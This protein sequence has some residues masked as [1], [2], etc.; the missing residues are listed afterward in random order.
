MISYHEFLKRKRDTEPPDGIDVPEGTLHPRLFDWQKRIVSWAL[1]VGR[2]AIWADT[3]LGKTMMQLEWARRFDG[4]RLVVAPLAVCEQTC[5]EARKL[6]L[7]ATYVRTPDE[8]TGDG[9]WVTSVRILREL[10]GQM[11]ESMLF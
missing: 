5:R 3:G 8:I 1:K 2:A 6:D 9:V 10:D 11:H 4:R 7:T